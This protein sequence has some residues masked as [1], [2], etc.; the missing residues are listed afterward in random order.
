MQ[1]NL[2]IPPTRLILI[3]AIALIAIGLY[4]AFTFGGQTSNLDKPNISVWGT[5]PIGSLDG[6]I[7]G[8]KGVEA[9]NVTY[10][11]ISKAGYEEKVLNA[12]AAGTGP[13]VFY[14][15]N[16]SAR[17]LLPVLAPLT[18]PTFNVNTARS[19]FPSVFESD[20]VIGGLA[21]ALPLYIDTM[22][23]AYNTRMFDSAA[24]VAPPKT[25]EEFEK[26]VS[27]LRTVSGNGQLERPAAA[28]GGTV[29]TVKYSAELIYLLMLQNGAKIVDDKGNITIGAS[30]KAKD[31][32]DYYLKFSNTASPL[33]I[34]SDAQKE[35]IDAFAAEEVAI[36]F[37]YQSDLAKIKAKNQ[38]L[39]FEI[40][41]MPQVSLQN[42]INFASY[43]G[44][45]VS[46]QSKN[47]ASAWKFAIYATT[48]I[49]QAG[50][51]LMSTKHPPAIRALIGYNENDP[52]YKVFTKQALSA[53]G[54]SPKN[55]EAAI[56]SLNEALPK[57]ISGQLATQRA[58][59]EVESQI[60]NSN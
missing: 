1:S 39:K 47:L 33:Y 4:I 11:Q 38:F 45:A 14:L 51:Y 49:S 21:Y 13:D 9:A 40:A 8:Y 6:A 50:N 24:I 57:I 17:K 46:K 22:V 27:T 31:A 37:A 34:W 30:G 2:P 59:S 25:W 32:V 43:E 7:N 29:K 19:T 15:S 5:D 60:N 52:I 56:D 44:L 55:Y 53:V 12:L 35:S 48:D 18:S 20:F 36:I 16:H 23:M 58:L 26:T 42:N 28:I 3:G 41:P 10:T 54:F